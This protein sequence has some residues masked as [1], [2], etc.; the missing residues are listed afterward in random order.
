MTRKNLF[1]LVIAFIVGVSV[2]IFYVNRGLK[3][4]QEVLLEQ[5]ERPTRK[6]AA[7]PTTVMVPENSALRARLI[8]EAQSL[9]QKIAEERLRLALQKQNLDNLKARRQ[10]QVATTY[11]SQIQSVNSQILDF[12]DELHA[13][14]LLETE[15]NQKA[16]DALRNQNSQA[17]VVRDQIDEN[18]RVQE[19]LMRKTQDEITY[20]QLNNLYVNEQQARLEGL[21]NLLEAQRQELD[22]M[23]QQRLAISSQV[24]LNS[25][26]LQ[27]DKD[28]ALSDIAANREDIR[29]EVLALRDQL[30]QLQ[31][32][33]N[34]VRSS[35]FS[36]NT[37]INQAQKSFEQQQEV[38]RSLEN[39]LQ[40]KT[41]ELNLLR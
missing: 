20:W 3:Q 1:F 31:E 14:D 5:A 4:T 41:D 34:Q 10:Q 32:A 24:L 33:Q 19:S 9:E 13:Y 29:S 22:L 16:A 40:Q 6:V 15:I 18:I 27:M 38:I 25:Q 21:Q 39:S 35:Q 17:Q 36:L 7:A 11:S 30:E 28:Q 2:W 8:S 23:R 37:Q 26:S 12:A